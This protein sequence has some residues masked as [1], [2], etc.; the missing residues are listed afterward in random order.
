MWKSAMGITSFQSWLK[1]VGHPENGRW[2]KVLGFIS[3]IKLRKSWGAS[4][5]KKNDDNALQKSDNKKITFKDKSNKDLDHLVNS[6][7]KDTEIKENE[8][9]IKSEKFVPDGDTSIGKKKIRPY[10]KDKTKL[11]FTRRKKRK[12]EPIARKKSPI[13]INDELRKK[14]VESDGGTVLF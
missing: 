7:E 2:T 6:L 9:K 10:Q 5:D 1:K 4:D 14:M 11:G 3:K 13:L 8:T 12:R